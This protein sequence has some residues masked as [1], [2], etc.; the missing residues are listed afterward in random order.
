[1]IGEAGFFFDAREQR[2]KQGAKRN[3]SQFARLSPASP[4][5][6]PAPA[7]SSIKREVLLSPR[8]KKK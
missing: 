6:T 4:P 8:R 5:S 7:V 2:K 3:A 1:M